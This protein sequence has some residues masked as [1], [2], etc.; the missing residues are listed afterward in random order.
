MIIPLEETLSIILSY[1]INNF[2]CGTAI[3]TLMSVTIATAT[4]GF[5]FFIISSYHSFAS[6]LTVNCFALASNFAT[7]SFED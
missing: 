6:F 7:T 4:Q 1:P 5:D 3:G 2:I